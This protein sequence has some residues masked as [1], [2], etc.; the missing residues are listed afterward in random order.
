MEENQIKSNL[1]LDEGQNCSLP[2]I[3]EIQKNL[4]ADKSQRRFQ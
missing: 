3:N 4:E 2:K 1:P